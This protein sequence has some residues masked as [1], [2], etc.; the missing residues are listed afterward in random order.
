MDIILTTKLALIDAINPCA[1]AIQVALLSILLTK[2]RREALI[3]GILF[4]I[5]IFL[6]YLLY[7]LILHKLLSYFY[8]I[9]FYLLVF[10]L[11]LMIIS[12][13]FAYFKYKPGFVSMELPLFLRP[14]VKKILSKV[15]SY[16]VSIPVAILISLFLLPCTSGP[17]IIFLGLQKTINWFLLL[18]YITIFILPFLL[19]TFLIYFGVKPE[20]ISE[21]REKNIRKIHLASGIIL[22]LVLIYIFMFYY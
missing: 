20:K 22:L 13:F 4:S 2:S 6:M 19:I 3:G 16:W 8:S 10:L 18:Y 7:G 17:Y 12:Q 9:I 14:Y 21:W 5:T 15:Y 1:I 11:I